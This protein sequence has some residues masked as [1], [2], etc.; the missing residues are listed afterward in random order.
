MHIAL[1]FVKIIYF[2]L[3]GFVG[4][5]IDDP[6]AIDKAI[7]PPSV[8]VERSP[9]RLNQTL[10][11]CT[12][13]KI[14]KSLFTCLPHVLR[15]RH[16]RLPYRLSTPIVAISPPSLSRI[17]PLVW[18]VSWATTFL[19]G[20]A[21]SLVARAACNRSVRSRYHRLSAVPAHRMNIHPS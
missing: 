12:K 8:R 15:R 7:L 20:F 11:S 10:R 4:I 18:C 13:T 9:F 6:S 21:P 16:R 3:S 2:Y 5:R 17:R 14:M 19:Q 1:P